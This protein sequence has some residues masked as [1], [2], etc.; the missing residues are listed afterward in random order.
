MSRWVMR[1][2]PPAETLDRLMRELA[3]PPAAA[4]IFARRGFTSRAALLPPLRRISIPG[5]SAGA[6]RLAEALKRRERIRIHGDYDADGLTGTAILY[7]GLK[8]LG[9]VVEAFFPHRIEEGYGVHPDKVAAHAAACDLFVTVDCGISNRAELAEL[10]ER[11]VEVIVTDHH[12]PPEVLP[13]GIVIH[14]AYAAELA[15]EAHP[16]G[17]GMA[18]LLLWELHAGLGLPAPEQ[19]LDLAAVGAIA[20]VVPL[21]GFNRA[22]VRSGLLR[23]RQ[24][25]HPGLANLVN[26]HCEACSATEVAFRIAPRL[27]AAGRLGQVYTAFEVLTAVEP[28][29]AEES[30]MQLSQLNA[31]RQQIEE[32]MLKRILPTLDHEA[33][34]YVIHDPTGH[35]GVMGIVASRVLERFYKPVFIVAKGRGSVRS[36]PGISAVDGLR[37]AA[38]HLGH[39]G[40]H[41]LAAGFSIDETRLPAFR[42][43]IYAYVATFPRPAAEMKLDGALE[44][45]TA[46]EAYQA[47]E[48]LEPIG[49]DNPE[50]IFFFSGLPERVR[51]IGEGRHISFHLAGF[52]ALRWRDTGETLRTMDH[53]QAAAALNL[54]RWNGNESLELRVAAYREDGRLLAEDP[55]ETVQRLPLS[56]AVE[57]V[58]AGSLPSYATGPGRAYLE[59]RGVPVVSPEEA[60]VWFALPEEAAP[61]GEVSLAFS[62]RL[63][64]HLAEPLVDR[65]QLMEAFTALLRGE[66]TLY[67]SVFEEL[68]P[69]PATFE[70]LRLYDSPSYRGLRLLQSA[71]RRLSLAYRAGEAALLA[72]ALRGY[73]EV[74]GVQAA[75][76]SF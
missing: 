31:R 32:E 3:L 70:A 19:Y 41:A 48:L 35:P 29:L 2:V 4:A 57:R 6:G 37:Y 44:P 72:Q 56:E 76:R 68:R 45:A 15:S 39:F 42:D 33:P 63:L 49:A 18:Y 1:D 25:P 12:S 16:S 61:L 52:R 71:G 69:L 75:Q 38:R 73:W 55:L 8:A 9:G 66:A 62:E 13:P 67:R 17:A 46:N 27:N 23:L 10:V 51:G 59:E 58:V 74:R 34:A 21:R 40:G 22:L 26:A 7:L 53:V 60:Q 20:D 50:P 14:P 5:L 24:S 11:G 36:T 47:L 64:R 65:E 43:A 30:A 54:N 28:S